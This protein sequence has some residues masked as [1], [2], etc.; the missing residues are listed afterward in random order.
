MVLAPPSR[1]QNRGLGR[2]MLVADKDSD[3]YGCP[4]RN[5]PGE[6]RAERITIDKKTTELR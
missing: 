1:M 5:H 6:L 3:A 2:E 4:N